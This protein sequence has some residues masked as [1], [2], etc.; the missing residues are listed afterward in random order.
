MIRTEALHPLSTV[1]V[2]H[3]PIRLEVE[4]HFHD[5]RFVG[6]DHV[7][8]P[9]LYGHASIVLKAKHR[10]GRWAHEVP[11]RPLKRLGVVPEVAEDVPVTGLAE[12]TPN[13]EAAGDRAGTTRVVVVDGQPPPAGP[14]GTTADVAGAALCREDR[15][16]LLLGDAV[17]PLDV[18][19]PSP[20]LTLGQHR[21]M[22]RVAPRARV[23]R[24]PLCRHAVGQTVLAS[25]AGSLRC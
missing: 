10:L 14:P 12:E 5:G 11:D 20:S 13:T 1:V 3:F 18:S 16:V 19:G 22:V 6:I 4:E 21:P 2:G 17:R 23:L 9:R 24:L 7:H 15:L 25:D 8:L